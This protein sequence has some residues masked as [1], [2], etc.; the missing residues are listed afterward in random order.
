MKRDREAYINF[1]RSL[2][3][4]YVI[5]EEMLRNITEID[6]KTIDRILNDLPKSGDFPPRSALVVTSMFYGFYGKRFTLKQI[7]SKF[8]VTS[9]PIHSQ[10]K[11]IRKW[12][13]SDR[14]INSFYQELVLLFTFRAETEKLS[15]M[16]I[17][18][19]EKLT[20]SL[21]NEVDEIET[22]LSSISTTLASILEE[23]SFRISS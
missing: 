5:T 8:N 1:I 19:I 10:L 7:A 20:L 17:A 18:A 2:H 4:S 23:L 12:L 14:H 11:R 6:M 16:N 22:R 21:R 3:I 13:L 9:F 15:Q